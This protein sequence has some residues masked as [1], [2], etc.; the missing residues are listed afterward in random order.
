[1]PRKPALVLFVLLAAATNVM[2]QITTGTVGGTVKDS[3]GG[4]LVGATVT[5]TSETRGTSLAPVVTTE[6]GDFVFVNVPADTYTVEVS[7]DGFKRDR[8]STRLNSS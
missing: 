3:Q 6:T 4:V 5:L 1:M 7:L 2:G 8:K